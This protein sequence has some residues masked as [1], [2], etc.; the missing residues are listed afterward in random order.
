ME[1]EDSLDTC[2]A[3]KKSHAA[4]SRGTGGRPDRDGPRGE[5]ERW[6]RSRAPRRVAPGRVPTPPHGRGGWRR[7][8][9]GEGGDRSGWLCAHRRTGWSRA[10]R[11]RCGSDVGATVARGRGDRPGGTLHCSTEH[12]DHYM[13]G[14]TFVVS[15]CRER[16]WAQETSTDALSTADTLTEPM[17]HRAL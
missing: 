3:R 4:R 6:R 16:P 17:P 12:F 13:C 1:C 2:A 11:T 15:S 8:A 10:S 5:C 14:R 9:C 7:A